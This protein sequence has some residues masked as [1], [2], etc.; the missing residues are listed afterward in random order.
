M[1]R[2]SLG[3]FRLESSRVGTESS[4]V[5]LESSR[6]G[7][8]SSHP[9]DA[10]M[11]FEKSGSGALQ[12]WCNSAVIMYRS[13]AEPVSCGSVNKS[14]VRPLIGHSEFDE[15]YRLRL[16]TVRLIFDPVASNLVVR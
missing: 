13:R 3:W 9:G 15:K 12:S 6:V 7:T 1:A 5:R 2:L 8:E 16:E 10:W 4:R 14:S 11:L